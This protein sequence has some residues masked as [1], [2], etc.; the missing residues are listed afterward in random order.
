MKN[1][2][3]L[4]RPNMAAPMGHDRSR[5]AINDDEE[6]PVD[7]MIKKTGCEKYHYEVQVK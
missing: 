4:K 6:D 3:G 7:A 2:N 5:K 1:L